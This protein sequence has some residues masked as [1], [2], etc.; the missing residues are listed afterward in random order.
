MKRSTTS[1]SRLPI[2]RRRLVGASAAT[3]GAAAMSGGVHPAFVGAQ[4]DALSG[5]LTYWH[6]F[7]SDSEMLG[8]EQATA[9]FAEAYPNITITSEN[10]PNADYMT[11]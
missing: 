1:I 3:L 5:D 2:T 8:L 7:T 9:S 11:Q 6:H 4:D 10:I